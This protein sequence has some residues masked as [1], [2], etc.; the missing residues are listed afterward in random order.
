MCQSIITLCPFFLSFLVSQGFIVQLRGMDDHLPLPGITIGDIGMKFGNGAYN[1]MDNGVLRFDHVRIPRDQ[2]LMRYAFLTLPNFP[3]C[4]L[5]IIGC[6]LIWM[7]DSS[8]LVLNFILNFSTLYDD[9]QVLIDQA[10][11]L[12]LLLFQT[13]LWVKDIITGALDNP[14]FTGNGFDFNYQ[15][16]FPCSIF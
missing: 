11:F 14:L 15:S 9:A 4:I 12:C 7:P 16:L 8:M 5:L 10:Y 6:L 1:S 13:I 2:M 3:F